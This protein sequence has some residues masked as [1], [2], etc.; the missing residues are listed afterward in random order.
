MRQELGLGQDVRLA[1]LIYG[2]HKAQMDLKEDFLPQGWTCILCTGGHAL[3]QEQL[4]DNF[5][6]A[7][8]DAYTPDLVNAADCVLGKIGYG[9]MSECLSHGVPLVFVRRDFFNEE[10]FLR[11]LLEVYDCAV[12]MRRRD[13]FEGHWGPYLT[14]ACALTPCYS[15][16]TNG[17]EVVATRLVEIG[18]SHR[19]SPSVRKLERKSSGIARLRDTIVWGYLLQTARG[20]SL[21]V[22]EWY[23]CGR[24]PS[25]RG[26]SLSDGPL[27][28]L[29]R[30]RLILED[31]EVREGSPSVLDH[32]SDLFDFLTLLANLDNNPPPAGGSPAR[33]AAGDLPE[34]NGL[35][36][37]G[38]GTHPPSQPSSA[39]S[40]SRPATPELPER[41]ASRG[42]FRWEDEVIVTRAPGRLDVMGGIADYSGSLV[43]QLPIREACLVALQRHP[44]H[45]QKLWR[46]IQ[47][48]HEKTGPRAALRVVSYHADETNRAPTFDMDID[49]LY[50]DTGAPHPY[51]WA[52]E[53]FRKDPAV[54]WASYVAGCLVVLSHE[55]GVRFTEGISMLICS[56]I[57]EG[58]GVSSSAAVEVAVMMAVIAAHQDLLPD[59]YISSD[60]ERRIEDL[61]VGREIAL[62]CQ[63]VENLVVGA[64]CGLMDQM[65]SCLGEPGKL[66]ALDCRTAEVQEPV[67]LPSQMRLWGIDSGIRHSVGGASY[68]SVRVGTFMGLRVIKGL[69]QEMEG[70]HGRCLDGGSSTSLGVECLAEIPPSLFSERY[71]SHLPLT[72]TGREFLQ[73]YGHHQDPV[74]NIDLDAT[75]AVRVP[76][77]H[78]IHENFRVQ[79]FRKVL[80]SAE[81]RSQ[82]EVLG[83]LMFQS[84]ASYSSCGLGSEGTNRLVDLVREEMKRSQEMGEVPPLSGAKITGGGCGG[85]VC[86][87][88][89]SGSAGEMALKRVVEKYAMEVGHQPQVF[90][91][92]SMGAWKFG[93]LKILSRSLSS[94][95][96]A[97]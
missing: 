59:L 24:E 73:R 7:P 72:L 90:L 34:I 30:M 56:D 31:W 70:A 36:L 71:E 53:Y 6:L 45:K 82:M 95:R 22:P 68:G 42:L 48:R 25:R 27:G 77:G 33:P 8:G 13:F 29:S 18:Q 12:E 75:Y 2:G 66:L 60:P 43:L 86:V 74:T 55:K 4:P 51:D 97:S 87:L 91:G 49:D 57:P 76:T 93:Y 16:P 1:V 63:K 41:R 21:E 40:T 96:S 35:K 85:T 37:E 78:P 19:S 11:K 84:H 88:G 65:A 61:E 9:T 10:P 38:A 20:N 83:E 23:V 26:S 67:L 28:S 44:V 32:A 54:W 3:G 58:K 64:P 81:D 50:D 89:H 69:Q 52:R 15:E 14:R 39:P 47:A 5:L 94:S 80:Y 92:T 62:L 79:T 17:A 46:H